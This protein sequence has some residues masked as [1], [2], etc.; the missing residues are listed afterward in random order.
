MCLVCTLSL[1]LS[2]C[3]CV[4]VIH[5]QSISKTDY[6]LGHTDFVSRAVPEYT[7]AHNWLR[8]NDRCLAVSR[9]VMY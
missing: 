3:V 2:L 7:L 4:C 5:L 1:S 6:P 8:W 9:H